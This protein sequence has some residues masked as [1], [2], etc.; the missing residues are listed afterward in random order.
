MFFTHIVFNIIYFFHQGV[1][2]DSYLVSQK[3]LRKWDLKTFLFTDIIII[4]TYFRLRT[5]YDGFQKSTTA[6]SQGDSQAQNYFQCWPFSVYKQL[7]LFC[8][9][10]TT[11]NESNTYAVDYINKKPHF[12]WQYFL[13]STNNI[14]TSQL[15]HCSVFSTVNTQ[16]NNT[17]V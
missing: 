11:W 2:C 1:H 15:Q 3:N 12:L 4:N 10:V 8:T 7:L 13:H 17:K 14:N 6:I 16:N 9:T 5:T